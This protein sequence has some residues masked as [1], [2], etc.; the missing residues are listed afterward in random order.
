MRSQ[1]QPKQVIMNKIY[2]IM[3]GK[4]A[5]KNIFIRRGGMVLQSQNTIIFLK[6]VSFCGVPQPFYT[7]PQQDSS[8]TEKQLILSKLPVSILPL[9]LG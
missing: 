4:W 5:S 1:F 7:V 3:L 6:N 9:K 8:L 2:I